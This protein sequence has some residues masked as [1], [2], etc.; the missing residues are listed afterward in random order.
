MSTFA[1]A[2]GVVVIEPNEEP[3]ADFVEVS[4]EYPGGMDSLYA[5]IYR[6]LVHPIEDIETQGTVYVNFVIEKDGS[7]TQIKVL[8][9][10]TYLMDQE[11]IR[12]ISIM[13][14]WIPGE[15]AGQV[16]RVRYTVPIRFALG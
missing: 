8:R 3:I 15:Q 13:P 2:Q 5:F 6:N 12:I 10:L 7:L 1:T 14:N 4:L 9:G 11:A 16:M